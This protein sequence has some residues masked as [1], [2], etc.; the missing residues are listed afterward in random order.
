MI[1]TFIAAIVIALSLF[2]PQADAGLFDNS[3]GTITDTRTGLVWQKDEGG[4]KTWSAALGYCNDL[5]LPPT[6]GYTDWRL[7]NAKELMSLTDDLRYNPSI[8]TT[9]F[10]NAVAS[11]YWSSTTIA[12]YTGYAWYVDFGGGGVYY[13]GKSSPFYVRC[14]RGG[15]GEASYVGLMRGGSIIHTYNNIQD[16]YNNA[17]ANDV[18]LAKNVTS[19]ENQ[20][21][22]ATKAVSLK[23]GYDNGFNP[24]SVF[25][26]ING[27]MTIIGGTVTIEK[28]IIK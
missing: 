23:G 10:P 18:I 1:W 20:T 22:V 19:T 15:Q 5:V 2:V 12:Y 3:N 26:T 13:I 9:Y 16:A 14:V 24:T 4:Q 17:E 8:D 21:F 7:P 25:T 28:I 6:D 27:N 11:Y